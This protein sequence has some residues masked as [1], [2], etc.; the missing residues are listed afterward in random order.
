MKIKRKL[1]LLILLAF[2]KTY[3][4]QDLNFYLNTAAQKN[5]ELKAAFKRYLATLEKIPQVKSLPDP[6][7][8]FG[9]FIKPVETKTGPQK[10]KLSAS[11]MFPW[12]GTLKT[13][14]KVQIFQ[15]KAAYEQFDQVES[16]LFQEVRKSYY[17]LYFLKQK[18]DLT[19]DNLNL[20]KR[21]QILAQR[22]ITIGK[23][24]VIDV[25]RA[26]M[27]LNQA[28]NMLMQLEDLWQAKQT[29]FKNLINT[30]RA[31]QINL[32]NTL[33]QSLLPDLR[34]LKKDLS[35]NHLLIRQD[36][37]SRKFKAKQE[38]AR[39]AGLPKFLIGLDYINIG[40][41]AIDKTGFNDALLIKAGI[42]I[43]LFRKKYRALIKENK[44]L[45][46]ANLSTQKSIQNDLDTKLSVTYAAYEDAIRRITLF[47]QQKKLARRATDLLQS[48]YENGSKNFEEILRMERQYI[49][50]AIQYEK[51]LS[52]LQ[53][54][55]AE[56]QFLI[57]K[58][59]I[60][61]PKN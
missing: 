39:K 10:F 23:T 37:L 29:E 27:A 53:K 28:L 55:I 36:F 14:G 44:L 22:K 43:P 60:K 40:T 25:I 16:R 42:T 35:H 26:Q 51:A 31:L 41:P 46:E 47:K 17:E 4:Q 15:A 57:G 58:N 32:P 49:T 7:L 30:D 54:R 50:Y 56:I 2:T 20:L 33:P 12:F 19:K 61:N 5:P 8:A 3:S 48:Q 13:A 18:I 9:Y 45:T 6:Q 38:W 21:F 24:S 1:L 52:D 11:Q 59:N 34:T